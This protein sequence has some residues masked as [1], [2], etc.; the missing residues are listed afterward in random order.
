MDDKQLFAKARNGDM[1]AFEQLVMLYQSKVYNLAHKLTG[2][3]DDASDAAQEAF[4]KLYKSLGS[5]KE[6]SSIS[7][8]IYRITYNVCIDRLRQ[9]KRHMVAEADETVADRSP[10]PDDVVIANDDRRRIHEAIR[11]LPEEYRAA[12]VLRDVNGHSYD[13]VA[14]ILGCSLGTVKSRISRGRGL[15]KEYLSHYLEQ[16]ETI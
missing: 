3:Y 1:T 14:A 8:W 12:V 2:N 16:T 13:E 10:T 6:Q 9:N 5:F 15:L 11:R 7:T 4:I